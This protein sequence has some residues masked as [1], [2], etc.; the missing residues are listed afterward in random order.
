MTTAILTPPRTFDERREQPQPCA[1]GRH[2]HTGESHYCPWAPAHVPGRWGA[3][4]AQADCE[5]SE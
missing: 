4:W 5:E 1:C 2:W 3:I